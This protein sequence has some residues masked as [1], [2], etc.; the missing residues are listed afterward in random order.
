MKDEI[1]KRLVGLAGLMFTTVNVDDAMA[2]Q[3][4][5]RLIEYADI[6]KDNLSNK[7][8]GISATI[9]GRRKS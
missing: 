1:V 8:T 7:K 5:G 2:K 6:I 3:W 9:Q 4:S